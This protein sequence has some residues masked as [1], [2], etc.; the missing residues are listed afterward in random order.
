[1][2]ALAIRPA[3][4]LSTNGLAARLVEFNMHVARF[5][6]YS[7]YPGA[8]RGVVVDAHGCIDA[9]AEP[10]LS[11]WLLKELDLQQDMDWQMDEP[12]K[13]LWLLDGPGIGR[14]SYELSLAMHRDWLARE[15]DGS[16]LRVL[17]QKIDPEARR[18]AVEE[19]PE[20][21]FRHRSPRVDFER[22]A[23]AEIEAALR[24]DGARTLLSMLQPQWYAVQGRAQ[25]YFERLASYGVA[26]LSAGRC[27]K[28]L[29]LICAHLI[30]RRLPQWAWLF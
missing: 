12:Q 8:L 14:L 25:L 21:L 10:A 11:R 29:E 24:A 6:H 18:F 2:S 23:P 30:P 27:D 28:A 9:R 26:S 19:A 5:A 17:Q 20:G 13:R 22:D 1:M 3:K 15:I 4:D 7:W 16:R